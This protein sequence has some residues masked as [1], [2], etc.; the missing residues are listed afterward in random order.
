MDVSVTCVCTCHWQ[1]LKPPPLLFAIGCLTQASLQAKL[2]SQCALGLCL[3]VAW[4]HFLTFMVLR[5]GFRLHTKR[6]PFPQPNL[7]F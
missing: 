3:L 1:R 4:V 6:K 5:S 2:A 7:F